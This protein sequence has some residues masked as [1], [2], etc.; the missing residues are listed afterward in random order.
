MSRAWRRRPT[1]NEEEARQ[2][3]AAA[4]ELD[5]KFGIGYT[6]LAAAL[7]NLG[8]PQEAEKYLSKSL[9]YLDGMTER[10]RFSTRGYYYLA[11]RD[12]QLCVKEYGELISRF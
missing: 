7:R 6:S 12:Y 4:V 9:R 5:P 2:N 8:R 3:F 10:E 11:T 1:A